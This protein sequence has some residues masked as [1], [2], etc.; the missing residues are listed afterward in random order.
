MDWIGNKYLIWSGSKHSVDQGSDVS[1][2]PDNS[3]ATVQV[4]LNRTGKS[5]RTNRSVQGPATRWR[6]DTRKKASLVPWHSGNVWFT[7]V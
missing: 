6:A 3:L 2:P 1:E 7:F 4:V 5:P